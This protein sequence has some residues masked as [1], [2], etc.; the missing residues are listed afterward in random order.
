M[1]PVVFRIASTD[2]SKE[3]FLPMSN[4]R[5]PSRLLLACA[6]LAMVPS[7]AGA[8]QAAGTAPALTYADLVDLADTAP[9]VVRAEIRNQATVERERSPGL[10]PGF[11][12]LYVEARTS[13]L[14][15]GTTPVGESLR[16]LVD[17]PM[18]AKGKAPKLKKQDVILF[19]RP[20]PGHA[21]IWRAGSKA[22]TLHEAQM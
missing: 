2:A 3:R 15:A 17:V 10:A 6:A 19:A 7:A 20:V 5:V 12:R 18:T 22:L 16:Y 4:S 11:V 1:A 13:A 21:Q 14:I 8:Q 9:L